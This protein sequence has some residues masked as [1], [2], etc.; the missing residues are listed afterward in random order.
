[1]ILEGG[2]Y[3]LH[4]R[5]I[6]DATDVPIS[7]EVLSLESENGIAGGPG[8]VLLRDVFGALLASV[9]DGGISVVKVGVFQNLAFYLVELHG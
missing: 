3:L 2:L 5:S 6:F 7:L 1:M 8:V 9:D 4:C